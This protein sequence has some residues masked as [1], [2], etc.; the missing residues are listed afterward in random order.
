[1]FVNLNYSPWPCT[2]ILTFHVRV[3]IIYR[4]REILKDLQGRMS[5]VLMPLITAATGANALGANDS[6]LTTLMATLEA[7]TNRNQEGVTSLW[8]AVLESLR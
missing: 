7:D 4:K 6:T 3:K 2:P 5:A 8:T 1:M